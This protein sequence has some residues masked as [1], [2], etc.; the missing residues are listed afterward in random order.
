MGKS[1]ELVSF[2][3]LCIA[4][5]EFSFLVLSILFRKLDNNQIVHIDDGAFKD[6][7]SLEIL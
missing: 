6:F 5:I 3:F 7:E 4:F 2:E 1:S